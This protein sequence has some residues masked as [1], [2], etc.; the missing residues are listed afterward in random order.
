M[1]HDGFVF[2]CVMILA[3][4]RGKGKK[5]ESGSGQGFGD[6]VKWEG[7]GLAQSAEQWPFKPCVVGSS[8]TSP[9]IGFFD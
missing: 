3:S 5:W 9:T 4:V 7:G 6:E 2:G 1:W 8:P